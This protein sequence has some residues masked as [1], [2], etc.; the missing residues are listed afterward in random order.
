MQLK[1]SS[2][3]TIINLINILNLTP[4]KEEVS[5]FLENAFDAIKL[6]NPNIKKI[7]II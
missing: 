3:P 7:L 1:I 4:K 6:E 5:L 2:S